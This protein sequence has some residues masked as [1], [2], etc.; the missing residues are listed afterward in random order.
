MVT[1]HIQ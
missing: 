1:R